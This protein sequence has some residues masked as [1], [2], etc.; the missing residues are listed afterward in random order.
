[1]IKLFTFVIV[2]G[3]TP[4]GFPESLGIRRGAR[5]AG[6]RTGIDHGRNP[7]SKDFSSKGIPSICRIPSPMISRHRFFNSNFLLWYNS[8][9]SFRGRSSKP[10]KMKKLCRETESFRATRRWYGHRLMN[11]EYQLHKIISTVIKPVIR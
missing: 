1:M 8:V 4:N 7:V 5:L 9:I 10:H 3:A 2:R 11:T 6:R